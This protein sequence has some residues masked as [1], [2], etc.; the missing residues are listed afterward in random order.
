MINKEE[1]YKHELDR[2]F[3]EDMYGDLTIDSNPV[4][5]LCHLNEKIGCE[6]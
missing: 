6:E 1:W 4:L 3:L 5:V 2:Q